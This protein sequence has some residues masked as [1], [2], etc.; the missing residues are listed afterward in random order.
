MKATTEERQR[1]QLY[2]VGALA[3][4]HISGPGQVPFYP[5]LQRKPHIVSPVQVLPFPLLQLCLVVPIQKGLQFLDAA[6]AQTR[7]VSIVPQQPERTNN[8]RPTF[9]YSCTSC[10]DWV[11]SFTSFSSAFIFARRE[12]EEKVKSSFSSRSSVCND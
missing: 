7:S 4:P 6:G 3:L 1:P 10:N 8:E 2:P 5:L 9:K 12:E 11:I